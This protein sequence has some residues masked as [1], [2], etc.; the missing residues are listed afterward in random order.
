MTRVS[1]RAEGLAGTPEL[2]RVSRLASTDDPGRELNAEEEAVALHSEPWF[3]RGCD[4]GS[5]LF[6]C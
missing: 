6:A 2:I 1:T 3:M 4:S 5:G